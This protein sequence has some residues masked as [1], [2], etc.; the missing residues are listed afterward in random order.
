M[1]CNAA[2]KVEVVLFEVLEDIICCGI[3]HLSCT[4]SYLLNK[5]TKSCLQKNITKIPASNWMNDL[6]FIIYEYST[7]DYSK[8]NNFLMYG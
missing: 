5:D 2:K 4:R 6:I 1:F 3:H 7:I 8:T